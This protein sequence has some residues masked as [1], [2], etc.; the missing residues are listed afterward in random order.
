MAALPAASADGGISVRQLPGELLPAFVS[1]FDAALVLAQMPEGK[2]GL[3]LRISDA[4]ETGGLAA[5]RFSNGDEL[6]RI[7]S[8][9]VYTEAAARAMVAGKRPGDDV[10][11][12]VKSKGAQRIV[13][14]EILP[15]AAATASPPATAANAPAQPAPA[16]RAPRPAVAASPGVIVVSAAD[17]ERELAQYDPIEL[18]MAAELEMVEDD[19][20]A[21]IGLGSPRFGDISLSRMVG[22][23]NGDVV[24][25]VN[26]M[27]VTSE[28]AIFAIADKL[29]GQT[30]FTAQILRAGRPAT[31]RVKVQ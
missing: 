10:R 1:A 31:L 11:F 7:D 14:L 17:L 13:A 30:D 9:A 25:G 18:V 26:G 6:V 27:P 3:Y 29:Q 21:T 5:L 19:A 20:G 15:A 16:P 24:M 23:R 12:V 28:E 2:T 22:L 4:D 8:E